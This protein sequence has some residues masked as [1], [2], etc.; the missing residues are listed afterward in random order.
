MLRILGT[1]LSAVCL[2]YSADVMGDGE[3][4]VK[5]SE[6]KLSSLVSQDDYEQLRQLLGDFWAEEGKNDS[7]L[8]VVNIASGVRSKEDYYKAI[9]R[10]VDR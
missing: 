3:E 6:P 5:Y 9:Y 10:S 8:N 1:C 4:S 2:F 7:D